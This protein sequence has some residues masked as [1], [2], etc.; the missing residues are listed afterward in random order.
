MAGAHE[1]LLI[2]LM[3]NRCEPREETPPSSREVSEP[4]TSFQEPESSHWPTG[5]TCITR[6]RS[7]FHVE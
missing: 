3:K 7:F 6:S 2:V 1:E 4:I 5:D